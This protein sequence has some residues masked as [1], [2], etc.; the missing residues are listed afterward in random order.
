MDRGLASPAAGLA[1]PQSSACQDWQHQPPQVTPPP[2]PAPRNP[3]KHSQDMLSR[4]ITLHSHD[5]FTHN[6]SPENTR[7]LLE[8]LALVWLSVWQI[9]QALI[10]S[11]SQ[12]WGALNFVRKD[13]Y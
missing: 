7:Q 1:P 13:A 3:E 8:E 10:S 11:C 5:S 2:Q 9:S 6:S 4:E 12:C